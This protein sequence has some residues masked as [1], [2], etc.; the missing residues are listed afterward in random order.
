MSQTKNET[1]TL[2]QILD[3]GYTLIGENKTQNLSVF[4]DEQGHGILTKY[5][6][7]G[8]YVVI[9]QYK[10]PHPINYENPTHNN[11]NL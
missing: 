8:E 3:E 5:N 11:N 6:P 9:Q 2:N 1:K 4:H 10:F 7:K